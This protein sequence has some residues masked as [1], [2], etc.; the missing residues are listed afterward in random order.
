MSIAAVSVVSTTALSQLTGVGNQDLGV[1]YPLGRVGCD[2]LVQNEP[3]VEVRVRQLSSDLLDD[4]DVL[5]VRRPLQPQYCVHGEV[6]KVVLVLR[7]DLA[8]QRRPGNVDQV[9]P[10]RLLVLS[11]V[12]RTA[13]EGVQSR[14][15]GDSVPLDN[16]LRVDFL[17]RDELLG[18]SQELGRENADRSGSVSDLVVL[19]FGDVDED[20]GGGVVEVDGFKDGRAVVGDGDALV[21][22]GLC[23][24]ALR[25]LWG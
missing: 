12:D 25:D 21:R 17:D 3:F 24:S 11:V 23:T 7:K 18:L 5:Q 4:L 2:R 6:R 22:G 15:R 19:D 20:L 10:E 9:L 8:R 16:G 1:L 13:S 14:A